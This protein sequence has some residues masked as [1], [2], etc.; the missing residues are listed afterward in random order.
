M[1]VYRGGRTLYALY[2]QSIA[3]YRNKIIAIS[4]RAM[5]SSSPS[6]LEVKASVLQFLNDE[7]IKKQNP[8]HA[9]QMY[10]YMKNIHPFYGIKSPELRLMI[11]QVQSQYKSQW[12]SKILLETSEELLADEYGDKK[13]LG[14]YLLGVPSNLKLIQYEPYI[15]E[16]LGTFI[17]NYVND[18]A[19]CDGLSSQVIRKLIALDDRTKYNSTERFATKV[20]S[21]CTSTNGDWKQRSSC[22]SFVCLARHGNYNDIILNIATNIIQNQNRFPQLGVGWVLRELSVANEDIVV[23]FIKNHYN[24]F[25]REGL[26]YAIEKMNKPLQKQLL[27]YDKNKNK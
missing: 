5:S 17:D 1:G 16:T 21:W 18:W 3:V 12:T 7:C 15:I 13:M 23:R 8:K 10:R 2:A 26:R 25:T 4:R 11:K 9:Q 20:Q 27:K 22:I 19:T 14:V 24:E 6:S